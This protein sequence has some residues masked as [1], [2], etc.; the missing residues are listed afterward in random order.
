MDCS[1]LEF[2]YPEAL[3][4]TCPREVFRAVWSERGGVPR[5]IDK[6]AFFELFQR[7]DVLV[8]NDTKVIK[9][10]LLSREGLE[11]VFVQPLSDLEWELLMPLRRWQKGISKG[12]SSPPPILLPEGRELRILQGGCPQKGLLNQPVDEDYFQKWGE[13]ALPPYIQKARGE[14]AMRPEDESW[15]QSSW[16]RYQGSCAAPTASLHFSMDDLEELKKRGVSVVSLTLHVG[17]GTFLPIHASSLK[18]HQMHS[19]WVHIPQ[20]T[21]EAVDQ[22]PKRV[23]AL[24]TTVTRALESYGANQLQAQDGGWSG[25]TNL[26]I[27]PGFSF[28]K[29]DILMTNFHQPR[30]TLLSMVYAFAGKQRVSE[31]YQWAVDQKFFLFSYG[32]L[33]IWK[34]NPNP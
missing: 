26:F 27:R 33:S 20:S 31:V 14:S 8:I 15:Y 9:R 22:C 7:G 17:L 32:D 25:W 24:G 1:E 16:A 18:D 23:W 30:S 28:Q 2:S 12:T 3:V 10:R 34:R 4:A 21:A 6:E 29:V 13:M 11:I 5:E 19:E